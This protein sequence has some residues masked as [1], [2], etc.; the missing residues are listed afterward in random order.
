[1]VPEGFWW[2]VAQARRLIHDND[3]ERL[4]ALLAEYPALLSWTDEDDDRGL[5]GMATSAYGALVRAFCYS[6][7]LRRGLAKCRRH[8]AKAIRSHGL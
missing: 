8:A 7:G 2:A 1:M 5:L 6:P 3:V 4:K